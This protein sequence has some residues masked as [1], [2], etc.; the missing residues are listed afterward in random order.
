MMTGKML[1]QFSPA[2]P[3]NGYPKVGSN[4]PQAL[5]EH[6][7]YRSVPVRLAE[8]GFTSSFSSSHLLRLMR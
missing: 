1:E 7:L 6:C 2:R 3:H 5:V 4:R 8:G